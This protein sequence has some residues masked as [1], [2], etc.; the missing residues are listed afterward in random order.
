MEE[1]NHSL[2]GFKSYSTHLETTKN[3]TKQKNVASYWLVYPGLLSYLSYISRAI[4]PRDSTAYNR[5]GPPRTLI[6]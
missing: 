6:N 2:I 5:L 1:T 3:K 4:L